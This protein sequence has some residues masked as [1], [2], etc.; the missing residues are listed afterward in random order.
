M[1][2]GCS[3]N[4]SKILVKANASEQPI[5]PGL[6]IWKPREIVDPQ[7]IATY[8][9]ID[10]SPNRTVTLDSIIEYIFEPPV[11]VKEEYFVGLLF[12]TDQR[13]RAIAFDDLGTGNA[14]ASI[15]TFGVPS[16]IQVLPL[17]NA[18]VM[19]S[20]RF[21]PLIAVDFGMHSLYI[22]L[23]LSILFYNSFIVCCSGGASY[24]CPSPYNDPSL[25]DNNVPYLLFPPS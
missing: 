2:F 20:F 10:L 11:G 3:A 6:T 13:N 23:A 21:V 8:E 12:S 17:S 19:R 16:L 22:A 15:Q 1:R 7:F 18:L 25:S 14:F 5:I 4:L 9:K 24:N